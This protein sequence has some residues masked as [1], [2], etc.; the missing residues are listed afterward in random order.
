MCIYF[1]DDI[2]PSSNNG[3]KNQFFLVFSTVRHGFGM[4]RDE[5]KV[6][7]PQLDGQ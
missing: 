2:V 3:I 1:A 7:E 5:K 4:F 6:R